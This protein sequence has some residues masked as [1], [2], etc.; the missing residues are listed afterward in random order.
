[1]AAVE[2]NIEQREQRGRKRNI[3]VLILQLYKPLHKVHTSLETWR[4]MFEIKTFWQGAHLWYFLKWP[5]FVLYLKNQKTLHKQ[6]CHW[7]NK[8]MLSPGLCWRG[9]LNT[10]SSCT[11]PWSYS[12]IF[13]S[14][15]FLQFLCA[16]AASG[17]MYKSVRASLFHVAWVFPLLAIKTLSTG[18]KT[19][20]NN[21]AK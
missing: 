11:A 7:P 19:P 16:F 14:C 5:L 4:D 18:K 10:W 6:L 8:K 17:L 3:L 13:I 1:M 15:P 9:V 20:N 2:H 12:F 21:Q